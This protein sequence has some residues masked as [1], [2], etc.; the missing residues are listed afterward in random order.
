[1]VEGQSGSHYGSQEKERGEKDLETQRN[2]LGCR[3]QQRDRQTH[4]NKKREDIETER[5]P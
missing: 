1:M 5:M 2:R 3:V 4:R